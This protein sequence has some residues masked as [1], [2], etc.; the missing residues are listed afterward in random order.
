ML[1]CVKPFLENEEK[2]IPYDGAKEH[3]ILDVDNS[4]LLS[5]IITEVEKVTKRPK[6]TYLKR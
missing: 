2:E 4:E 5:K 6:K 3:Y 1:Y